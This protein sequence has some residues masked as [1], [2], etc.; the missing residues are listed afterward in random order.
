MDLMGNSRNHRDFYRSG[1]DRRGALR[2]VAT[3]LGL[4]LAPHLSHAQSV[5][6]AS[7]NVTRMIQGRYNLTIR[8]TGR[9][10]G[11]ETFSL[12]VHG[13]GT[14]TLES[15][16]VNNDVNLFRS[17]IYRVDE[18]FR[19]LDC[20]LVLY[21]DG[22]QL[23]STWVT[24]KGNTLHATADTMGSRLTHTVEVPDAFSLV[25]H[26]GAA[27]GW[28]FWYLDHRAAR[29]TDVTGRVYMMRV[30]RETP[31]GVLGR[32]IDRPLSYLGTET[33]PLAGQDFSCDVYTFGRP[34]K[35][36]VTGEDR[37]PVRLTYE[38]ADRDFHLTEW[39]VVT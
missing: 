23:G 36:Y 28:H 16:I 2:A 1:L 27:D 3:G 9:S 32:M 20:H 35:L 38:A 29:N 5:I 7:V 33:V 4:G 37:I 19:P 30:N 10:F 6:G 31:V 13:D 8:S 26:A 39:K 25:P 24:V 17:T 21:K 14:R 34:A 15:Q 22:T 11:F 12:F 18:R